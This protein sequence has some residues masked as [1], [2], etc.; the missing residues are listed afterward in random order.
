MSTQS[1]PDTNDLER[2]LRDLRGRLS[3]VHHDL[4]NPLSIVSGNA[5]LLRELAKALGVEE[6]FHGPLEDLEAAVEKLTESADGLILVRRML[7]ELEKRVE[8]E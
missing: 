6:D 8:S 2:T 5:Q 3:R 1:T 4:N 7:G